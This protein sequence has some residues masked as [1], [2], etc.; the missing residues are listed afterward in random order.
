MH[1]C[2]SAPWELALHGEG[3]RDWRSQLRSQKP[4]PKLTCKAQAHQCTAAQA[5]ACTI[6]VMRQRATAHL[7]YREVTLLR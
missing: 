2:T 1:L 5:H 3:R 6:A 4:A 7:R